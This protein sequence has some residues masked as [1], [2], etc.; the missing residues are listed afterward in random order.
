MVASLSR[1][2][3]GHQE[4]QAKYLRDG[5]GYNQPHELKVQRQDIRCGQPDQV[6]RQCPGKQD[7]VGPCPPQLC[8]LLPQMPSWGRL[9]TLSTTLLPPAP[10]STLTSTAW[11]VSLH[12]AGK[13]DNVLQTD[14]L[15]TRLVGRRPRNPWWTPCQLQTSCMPG[16]AVW[17]PRPTP[18]RP[19]SP[20][21]QG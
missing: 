8:S 5:H 3:S 10:M 16:R 17:P 9:A 12:C 18:S 4:H 20:P 21:E 14:S 11:K 13:V 19:K 2:E 7:G 15:L 6:L 1:Q